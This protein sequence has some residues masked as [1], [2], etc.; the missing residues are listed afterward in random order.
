M[1][2]RRGHTAPGTGSGTASKRRQHPVTANQL[3]TNDLSVR[4]EGPHFVVFHTA[5][6]CGSSIA[7]KP[8]TMGSE[9]SI[10]PLTLKQT[11]RSSS[12]DVA[13]TNRTLTTDRCAATWRSRP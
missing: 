11:H 9:L 10:P 4:P 2:R 6:K 13:N 3:G 12:D 1:P 7:M 8:S 5:D